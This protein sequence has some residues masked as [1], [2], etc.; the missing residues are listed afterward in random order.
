M[1]EL[2]ASQI[3]YPLLSV[4]AL[5]V[6]II[7]SIWSSVVISRRKPPLG[8]ELAKEYATKKDLSDEIVEVNRRLDREIGHALTSIREQ[9]NEIKGLINTVN[10]IQRETERTLGRIEG[11]LDQQIQEKRR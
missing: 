6:V 2:L 9:G 8:E 5:V 11:K 4:L 10:K 7:T 3:M 1:N